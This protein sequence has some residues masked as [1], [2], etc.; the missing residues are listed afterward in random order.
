MSEEKS[1]EIYEFVRDKL[2]GNEHGYS[3]VEGDR[4]HDSHM[5]SGK[6]MRCHI[7]NYWK[8]FHAQFPICKSKSNEMTSR[9]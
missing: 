9:E 1:Q 5:L 6:M 4:S 2:V 7:A 8:H 3:L